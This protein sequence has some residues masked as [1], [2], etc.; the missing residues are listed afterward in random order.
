LRFIEE[1]EKALAEE[2]DRKL[3]IDMLAGMPAE[4]CAK[5]PMFGEAGNIYAQSKEVESRYP[6]VS[7][8]AFGETIIKMNYIV[9]REDFM[10]GSCPNILFNTYTG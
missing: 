4:E 9:F 8:S 5:K 3:A 2:L 6:T 1:I 10:V 7:F